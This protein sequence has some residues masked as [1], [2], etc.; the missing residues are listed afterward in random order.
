METYFVL[1]FLRCVF[2]LTFFLSLSRL[3]STH[4]HKR[5][6]L[7]L[8]ARFNNVGQKSQF[9]YSVSMNIMKDLQTERGERHMQCP[10]KEKAVPAA[11]LCS[12][13]GHSPSLL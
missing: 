9:W 7:N 12:L 1:Y 13:P 6:L 8:W 4:S 2:S 3:F 11:Q 10:P 5:K